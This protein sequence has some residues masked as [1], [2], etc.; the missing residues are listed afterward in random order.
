MDKYL[1]ARE[2]VNA[3]NGLFPFLRDFVD[4]DEIAQYGVNALNGLFP[5]LRS[6]QLYEN[7]CFSKCVN[8]LNGLFPFLLASFDRLA[9]VFKSVN[10]L[11]GLFPFLRYLLKLRI[12]TGFPALF[13]QVF[14]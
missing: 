5:F 14:V 13:L 11:N 12:N 7:D 9:H 1:K 10:A 8:A 2:C 6:L 3:P 4:V